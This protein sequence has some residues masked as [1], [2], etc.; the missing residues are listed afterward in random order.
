M[1]KIIKNLITLVILMSIFLTGVSYAGFADFDDATADKQGAEDLKKQEENDA[2]NAGKSS[3][4]Y[5]S[6]LEIEGYSLTPQFDKQTINY[7]INEEI[8]VSSVVIKAMAEDE[9]ATITGDGKIELQSGENN[10]KIDVKAENGTERTYF[11][12]LNKKIEKGQPKLDELKINAIMSN[13][14]SEEIE[15]SPE[16]NKDTFEYKCE[17]YNETTSIKL[18]AIAENDSNV[19]ITGNEDLKEGNN[20]VTVKVQA[21]SGEESV[22]K[23]NV[24]K[25][26][27]Q[28][29][30]LGSTEENSSVKIIV[31]ILVMVLV[32]I[33]IGIFAKKDK[34]RVNKH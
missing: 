12:K 21:E 29:Q 19:E 11:I 1:K 6:N 18:N 4:N 16:F 14:K 2:K 27:K 31:P 28:E 25:K 15:I 10:L 30:E 33:I 24:Y 3:N 26:E 5:L 23:I 8:N 32:V 20:V 7:S 22:Y 9:R 17:V 13:G 34:K